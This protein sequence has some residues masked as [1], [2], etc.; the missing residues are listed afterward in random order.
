LLKDNGVLLVGIE[1]RFGVGFFLGHNDHSGIPYTSLV[2]RPV[3]TFMLRRSSRTHYRTQLNPRKQYR[4]YTYS[5]NGY[6]ELLSEAGFAETLSYWA[7]PGY[8]QPYHLVPFAPPNWV[9]QHAVELLDHP[10][11][12]PRRNWIRRLKRIALPFSHRLTPDFV[13]LASKQLGRKTSLQTWVEKQLVSTGNAPGDL[14]TSTKSLA[15]ALHTRPFKD[16]SVVRIGNSETGSDLAYLKVFTGAQ[17]NS[18]HYQTEVANRAKVQE[19]LNAF[20]TTLLR[21]PHSYGTLQIDHTTY[22]LEA[23]ARGVQISG[24]V[25]KLGYFDDARRIERDFSQISHRIIELTSVLQ[26]VSGAPVINP[27]WRDVPDELRSR[28]PDLAGKLA[29]RRYFQE[30]LPEAVSTWIQHGD[31]TVENSH[32]DRT[33][34]AFEVFDWN[35]LAGGFPPLYDLFHFLFSTGYLA[36]AEEAVRFASEEDRWI[37]TFKGVFLSDVAFAKLARRFI[38]RACERLNVSPQQVP[39]LLL[40]FLIIQSH[41]L[42]RRSAVQRRIHLHALELCIAEFERLQIYWPQSQ[43][44]SQSVNRANAK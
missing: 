6:R 19:S 32:L 44:V 1:N 25:R 34:G 8:N 35:D 24:V 38:L 27:A 9:R 26:N 40:E 42:P 21:I 36:P 4:T 22:Y 5:E 30:A 23:A 3:A 11:P 37:A 16:A 12:A 33:T 18:S 17:N 41:D 7:D 39:T 20:G 2:P 15:W 29:E 14:A 10:T 28:R 31:L 13:L 43:S